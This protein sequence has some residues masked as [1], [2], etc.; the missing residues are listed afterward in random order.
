MDTT[1][2]EIS[3]AVAKFAPNVA[4]ALLGPAAGMGVSLLENLFGVSSDNLVNT[5]AA[6]PNAAVKLQELELQHGEALAK[7]TME[8]SDS[9]RNR[10]IKIT[11]SIGKRDPIMSF[12]TVTVV[13]GFFLMC[14]LISLTKQDVTDHDIMNMLTGQLTSGFLMILG[15]YYGKSFHDK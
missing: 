11:E 1:L 3:H 9:A 12:I 6:D 15:Y 7:L 13:I 2:Q 14:F 4:T 10:E 5:I 8:D